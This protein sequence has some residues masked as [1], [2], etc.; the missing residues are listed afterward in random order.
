[1]KKLFILL[2]L[3]VLTS[4]TT[5]DKYCEGFQDGYKAGYCYEVVGCIEPT[6]PICPTPTVNCSTGYKCGYNRGFAKGKA[7]QD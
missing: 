2:M 4:F 5:E 3:V 6:P 1:M 7:D